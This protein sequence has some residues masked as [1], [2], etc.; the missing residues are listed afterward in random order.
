MR[1]TDGCLLCEEV[2]GFSVCDEVKC[3][4]VKFP[5]CITVKSGTG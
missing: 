3:S 5:R 4:S 2:F 1:Q